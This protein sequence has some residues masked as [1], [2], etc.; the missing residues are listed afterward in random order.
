MVQLITEL[1]PG[2]EIL[3]TDMLK[4]R[5]RGVVKCPAQDH[6]FSVVETDHGAELVCSLDVVAVL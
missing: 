1:Q 2:T 4:R 5:M 6:T 3:F